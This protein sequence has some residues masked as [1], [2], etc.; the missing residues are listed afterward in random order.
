M[1]NLLVIISLLA[2]GAFGYQWSEQ[3]KVIE[4]LE[5]QLDE[6]ANQVTTLERSVRTRDN[7]IIQLKAQIVRLTGNDKQ[8]QQQQAS[9]NTTHNSSG[10]RS[11]GIG[12]QTQAKPMAT[13]NVRNSSR[14]KKP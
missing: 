10:N 12:T 11:S 14:F 3:R 1:K 9:R 8:K 2:A 7:Q 4:D 6:L 13:R 5:V